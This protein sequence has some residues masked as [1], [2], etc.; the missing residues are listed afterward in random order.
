MLIR[1]LDCT[2]LNQTVSVYCRSSRGC[3]GL[4]ASHTTLRNDFTNVD[5]SCLLHILT[6]KSGLILRNVI[7]GPFSQPITVSNTNIGEHCLDYSTALFV[8]NC[9][10][11]TGSM[12][13]ICCALQGGNSIIFNNYHVVCLRIHS[14][15]RGIERPILPCLGN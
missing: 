2:R 4:T 7:I 5:G 8:R 13:V 11:K 12:I 14:E 6:L 3:I 15:R 10:G 1:S 9:C